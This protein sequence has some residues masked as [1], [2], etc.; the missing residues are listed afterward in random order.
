MFTGLFLALAPVAN[1][2]ESLPRHELGFALGAG[3]APDDG[4]APTGTLLAPE[5]RVRVRESA[6][7]ID[8]Q[9]DVAHLALTAALTSRPRLR[10]DVFAHFRPIRGRRAALAV[11]PG[12]AGELGLDAI[13]RDERL[14]RRPG[15][16]LGLAGRLGLDLTGRQSHFE[17]G[18]YLHGVLGAELIRPSAPF[19]RVTLELA[20]VWGLRGRS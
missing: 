15:G 17:F 2:A 3:V 8:V 16:A 20:F 19:A 13:V 10:W 18:V 1:A 11:M 6:T 7:T 9:V 12:V 4:P 5:L 14:V